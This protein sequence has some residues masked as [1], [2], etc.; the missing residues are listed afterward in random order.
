MQSAFLPSAPY[1]FTQRRRPPAD[2]VGGPKQY[3]IFADPSAPSLRSC[4]GV[5]IRAQSAPIKGIRVVMHKLITLELG[6]GAWVGAEDDDH[7]T[8]C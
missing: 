5:L 7:S 4:A 3:S 2:F 6:E 1:K 8:S